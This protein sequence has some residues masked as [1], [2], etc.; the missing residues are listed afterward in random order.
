MFV[1]GMLGG[2][3][4]VLVYLLFS[5]FFLLFGEGS[6]LALILIECTNIAFAKVDSLKLETSSAV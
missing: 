5:S 2:E 3:G 1:L 6:T 4:F